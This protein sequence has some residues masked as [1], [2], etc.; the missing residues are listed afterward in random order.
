MR[1]FE[2]LL[3]QEGRQPLSKAVVASGRLIKQKPLSFSRKIGPTSY[4]SKPKRVLKVIF[5]VGSH[6]HLTQLPISPG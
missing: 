6:F 2:M 5:V 4:G 1:G 3:V